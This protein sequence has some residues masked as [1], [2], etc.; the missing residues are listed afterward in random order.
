MAEEHRFMSRCVRECALV[1]SDMDFASKIHAN[2]S[3]MGDVLFL[4]CA[5]AV[6]DQH[7]KDGEEINITIQ[8]LRR[9]N[10][11]PDPSTDVRKMVSQF[12]PDRNEI[13]VIGLSDTNE[14]IS[15]LF[16]AVGKIPE[17]YPGWTIIEKLS[18]FIRQRAKCE[19][20]VLMNS[21]ARST[22]IFVE[23]MDIAKFHLLS[24][25]AASFAPW[26]RERITDSDLEFIGKEL[27]PSITAEETPDKILEILANVQKERYDLRS[28]RIDRAIGDFESRSV[29]TA[30]ER[31]RS[32]VS[33]IETT[34]TAKLAE[35]G[36]MRRE[37]ER[38]KIL[39]RGYEQAI[40]DG[41]EG[42][43]AKYFKCNP[44]I[45]LL[46]VDGQA[47]D[48][49]V[50]GH[51]D[52]PSED[53]ETY[54][55]EAEYN[56]ISDQ[57]NYDLDD[58]DDYGCDDVID[59]LRAVLIDQTIKLRVCA[60]I[61]INF[62][63]GLDKQASCS[64]PFLDGERKREYG[65]YMPNI[66]I[67]RYTCFGGNEEEIAELANEGDYIGAIEQAASAVRSFDITDSCVGETFINTIIT[68]QSGGYARNNKCFELP[69][70]DV[71]DTNGA[72]NYLRGR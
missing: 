46:G 6:F 44:N 58:D 70:G 12:I 61:K 63:G 20:V 17:V 36:N 35:I 45:E 64:Y 62:P 55:D 71:V 25:M 4:A 48:F 10:G 15:P 40:R 47:I 32:E 29:K 33:N 7:L 39:I 1:N 65:T 43:L 19:A 13:R 66:H 9:G 54:I 68:G 30:L 27:I 34:I 57:I 52:N 53:T 67:D 5:R 16:N 28:I 11:I 72:I 38:N 2:D 8:N 3:F 50:K 51:L 22:A 24:A 41:K 60:R 42:D 31:T 26:Y 59:L 23:R 18:E 49:I 37:W 14:R 56:Y 69:N 21:E